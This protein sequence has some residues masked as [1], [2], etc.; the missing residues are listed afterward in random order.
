MFRKSLILI[1]VLILPLILLSAC[2]GLN[3]L[4]P[5]TEIQI[6]EIENISVQYGEDLNLEG[7][8]LLVKRESGN[9]QR[10]AL[11]QDMIF[12]F[13]NNLVGNQILDVWYEE[14][15]TKLYITLTDISVVG[16][17]ILSAPE[18][19][20]VTQ[21]AEL[22]LSGVTINIEY[23]NNVVPQNNITKEMIVGYDPEWEP[24]LHTVYIEYSGHRIPIEINVVSREIISMEIN[25]PPADLQYFVGETF[26]PSGLSLLLKYDN[27]SESILNYED[28][29]K[30]EIEFTYDFSIQGAAN[31]IIIRYGGF[32][33]LANDLTAIVAE[34][35]ITTLSVT[36]VPITKGL[37]VL[38]QTIISPVTAIVER[39]QIDWV[40]G[41]LTIGYDN[42]ENEQVTIEKNEV[43]L[44]LA[45]RDGQLI[46][47]DFRFNEIGSK[48]IYI[49]YGNENV[50]A[51]L[52]INVIPKSPYQMMVSDIKGKLVRDFI[53]G[54]RI[55]TDFLRY[56][57][58]YNNGTYAYD[59]DDPETWARLSESLLSNDGSSLDVRLSRTNSEGVQRINFAIGSVEAGFDI[60]VV[61][62]IPTSVIVVEPT[63]NYVAVNSTSVPLQGSSLYAEMK[64]GNP[65]LLSPIPEEY[66]SYINSQGTIVT[67][68][69]EVGSYDMVVNYKGVVE[70]V[71]FMV[72]NNEVYEI[73]LS[74]LAQTT[75]KEFNDIPITSMTMTVYSD[76]VDGEQTL[77]NVPV[78]L[79]YLYKYDRYRVGNQTII[80]RYKGCT[81]EMDISINPNNVSAIG[82]CVP[83]QLVYNAGPNQMLDTNMRIRYVFTDGTYRE[84]E[85]LGELSSYWSISGYDLETTGIQN[86]K[87]ERNFGLYSRSFEYQIEVLPVN[88]MVYEIAFDH[89]QMGLVEVSGQRVLIVGYREDINT[90]YFVEYIDG[91]GISREAIGNLKLQVKYTEE[92]EYQLI[93]L[94]PEYITRASYDKFFDVLDNG[95]IKRFRSV[96]VEYGGKQTLLNIYIANRALNSVEVY[97]LPT[98]TDYAVGQS[99]KLNGGVI[100]LN[101]TNPV[102]NG[103]TLV[104]YDTY[105]IIPMTDIFVLNKGYDVNKT[106]A[107][108]LFA[109]QPVELKYNNKTTYVAMKTYKKVSP[110]DYLTMSK[111]SHTY[112]MVSLPIATITHPVVSFSA[113]S[114][115]VSFYVNN[116]W[117][118]TPPTLPG[119]YNIKL[120]V[121]ENE[122]F[123]GGEYILP[124][125]NFQVI[126]KAIDIQVDYL[127]KEYGSGDPV[128]TWRTVNNTSLEPGD[129]I[130]IQISRDPGENVRFDS[131]GN[132]IGY[133]FHWQFDPNNLAQSDRYIIIPIFD[134]FVISRKVVPSATVINFQ[135]AAGS[136][137]RIYNAS[138]V[139][140]NITQTIRAEDLFYYDATT[141]ELVDSDG[142]NIG[143]GMPPTEPGSYYVQVGPNYLVTDV[144]AGR[145]YFNIQ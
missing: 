125:S 22:N 85:L 118:Q 96:V 71:P 86:V 78:T 38:G 90:R 50:F 47:K 1:V 140:N 82:M 36:T 74:P 88:Q 111:I 34:P 41:V 98:I 19:I 133:N 93:D 129:N 62:N 100:K 84:E 51:V 63:R 76:G 97:S 141:D 17:S 94:K 6:D 45:R 135:E 26:D 11:T 4:D 136:G 105:A 143:D 120:I 10:I 127:G 5:V 29:P 115:S 138:Y 68:F 70:T 137:G 20:S 27:K 72:E 144:N 33:T 39:D 92:G 87:I 25:T 53:D 128:F 109:T 117:T 24:G 37:S 57:I 32:R 142:D 91:Q 79:D 44:Y 18:E 131:L 30:D 81:G 108:S 119:D 101:Y 107:G 106:I 13:D 80:F 28:I 124:S 66:I 73:V 52:D 55:T 42:G 64:Y 60:N 58:L 65:V 46:P 7:V 123:I 77:Y 21:G 49:K 14:C 139:F 110:V 40:T 89:T 2:S 145:F 102:E 61:P 75:F 12:G 95:Q 16:I 104:D 83:P 112:G 132:V 35:R 103:D 48:K 114:T 122:Y 99:L 134:K 113:P 121:V 59:N 54:E 67:V 126:K 69:E 23:E 116:A 9:T 31:P 56:N 8:F 43:Y 3:T 15:N 130:F